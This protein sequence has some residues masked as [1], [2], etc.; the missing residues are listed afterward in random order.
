[1]K[2]T[3][4]FLIILL[5]PFF[6]NAQSIE[7]FSIDSGGASATAG[8]I[9]ILYTIGEVM[10]QERSAGNIQIS[11]GF[12]NPVSLKL[13]I[14]PKVFLQGPYVSPDSAGLMNDNL[15]QNNQIPTTS[16]YTDALTCDASVFTPT[17]ND[18]VVD[19][20]LVELRD[21][22]DRSVV[23]ESRSAL[24]QRDG[25]IVDVD[26]IAPVN[27]VSS[28]GT[29]FLLVG[30]RNHLSI[31]SATPVTVSS[32]TVVDLSA[33]PIAVFGGNNAVSAMSNNTFAMFGGDLNT[34][35]QILNG[36]LSGARPQLSLQ[37]YLN[38]DTDLDGQ[39]LNQDISV[40]IRPNLSKGI[41]Y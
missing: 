3:L 35:G 41:Q 24:L 37:G 16:P 12:I 2:T 22:A 27:F 6:G 9:Q 17:G 39:V 19:W 11:E 21:S 40:I 13:T 36:D 8:N 30:H 23:I 34:D 28:R 5:L 25:D 10:V 32:A 26:G 1:M 18:A 29:Y 7:K 20:V 38:A 33:D 31:L 14:N 15:R 4:T